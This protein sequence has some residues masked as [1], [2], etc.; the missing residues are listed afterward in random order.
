MRCPLILP[1]LALLVCSCDRPAEVVV[2]ET[3]RAT[4]LDSKPKQFATSN[5][6]FGQA[7]ASPVRGR[8]PEAWRELP[9]DQF[10]MLNYRFEGGGEVW[11]S[12]AGGTVLDNVNRWLGQFGKEP[13][14]TAALQDLRKVPIAGREGRWVEASGSTVVR[15]TGETRDGQ[16]MAGIITEIDGRVLT[17]KM[18]GPKDGVEAQK[19]ALEAFA[20]S[21]EWP[22]TGD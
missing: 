12:L 3:R 22:G 8:A 2:T 6:R 17:V 19:A 21:L 13:I 15:Q 18:V 11:V 1:V 5:E 7:G 10:R 20:A 16:A 9:G 14:T 4:L